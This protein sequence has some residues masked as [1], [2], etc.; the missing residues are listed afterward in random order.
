M[1]RHSK[2]IS[3]VRISSLIK[4]HLKRW[5]PCLITFRWKIGNWTPNNM[6][7][8]KLISSTNSICIKSWKNITSALQLDWNRLSE[9]RL[10]NR[11]NLR[12][13]YMRKLSNK[14]KSLIWVHKLSQFKICLMYMKRRNE[15]KLRSSSCLYRQRLLR[16]KIN[17][18][19][20]TNW[21]LIKTMSIRRTRNLT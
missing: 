6:N 11:D 18:D 17:K 13:E 10:N 15:S 9:W 3:Q 1:W 21:S 4:V 2:H 7:F 5:I 8:P 16:S 14:W 12:I 19:K 20:S